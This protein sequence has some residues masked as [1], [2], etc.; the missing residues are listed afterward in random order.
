MSILSNTLK[1]LYNAIDVETIQKRAEIMNGFERNY[2][3]A[4]FKKSAY[5][6]QQFML[7]SGLENVQM[8]PIPCDG[9]TAFN[10]Y[11][12]PQAWDRTG[13]SFLQI[14][15]KKLSYEDAMICDT[16][17]TPFAAGMW[18][19]PTPPEGIHAEV[20]D[21]EKLDQENPDVEGKF[22]LIAFNSYR[23][24][25][26]YCVEHNAAAIIVSDSAAPK[27]T[28]DEIRW[29][30]GVGRIGW[31]H[32]KDD[33]RG[34]IFCIT[35]RK[36]DFIRS[37]LAKG[38]P[39][40]AYGVMNTKVYDDELYTVTGIVPGKDSK[41]ILLIAHIYE[42]FLADDAAGASQAIAV[43]C[44]IR[45]LVAQKKL[46]PLK[47]TLR[48]IVSMERYGFNG[49][50]TSPENIKRALHVFSFD[51]TC[52]V[53][54]YSDGR[55]ETGLRTTADASPSFTDYVL[56]Y[57]LEQY[58]KVLHFHT[59]YGNL[60]DD[61]FMS[62][63]LMNIPCNW[64]HSSD[65]TYHH[66]SGW[67]FSD[68][69]WELARISAASLGLCAAVIATFRKEDFKEM[70]PQLKKTACQ[71]L[72][73]R[74]LKNLDEL[75]TNA[76]SAQY[77]MRK[78]FFL[79]LKTSERVLSVLHYYSGLFSQQNME[80]LSYD[81]AFN[82]A[83]TK[84]FSYAQ[85]LPVLPEYT[86]PAIGRAKNMVIEPIQ[87]SSIHSQARIPH[88]ERIPFG[89]GF[90]A[91]YSF[92][93]G[94]T[95]LYDAIINAEYNRD[96]HHYSKEHIQTI[97]NAVKV[98]EKYGYL[99]VKPFVPGTIK[100]FDEVLEKLGVKAGMKLF[101]HSS[102]SFLGAI[103][104][105]PK[106]VIKMLEKRLT[107]K[108][109]LAMP[110]FNFYKFNEDGVFDPKT[111]KSQVGILTET[112]RTMPGVTRSL[113][114][115][116]SVAA[117]GNGS[118][119]LLE[120][121]HEVCA[122]GE[123]SPLDILEKNDGYVLAINCANAITYMHT[124]EFAVHAPCILPFGEQYPVRFP[125]G[126]VKMVKTWSWRNGRCAL[127]ELKETWPL[128]FKRNLVKVE[129]FG[130]AE[131]LFFKLSDFKKCHTEVLKKVCQNCPVRPRVVAASVKE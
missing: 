46:P 123:G 43:A 84:L 19:M 36:A 40:K 12:I 122:V 6:C 85:K 131:L 21:W 105:G 11:I 67:Q 35:P 124:V 109:L 78:A 87:P 74:L 95:T 75:K 128:M 14:E 27:E 118:K 25:Y 103:E 59:E 119:E 2:G 60:S 129:T 100:E 24:A 44:A 9:K 54:R 98:F 72:E 8:I 126:S 62:G 79:S 73:E 69:D 71:T 97:I 15:D 121:H 86:A 22:V 92:C 130:N 93:D 58:H 32:T 28:Y 1:K 91:I 61:T 45:E 82:N 116:H 20:V 34:V 88:D 77:A 42:P 70:L 90:D 125:D 52:H 13:R 64:L 5:C 37:L 49:W 120:H 26:L 76:I 107:P 30:N 53:N 55:K 111:T 89:E 66:N 31:Y 51:S 23:K 112:F 83:A 29:S 48:V 4:N 50:F 127:A 65:R 101:V 39:V 7:A 16:N 99:R 115:T 63:A 38:K 18:S 114:P 41:E 108:G 104:G 96:G 113:N 106:A 33:K 57:A 81:L 110:A 47:H 94:K 10:D 17:Q 102:F 3:Q 117:W 68:P 56:R 80:R